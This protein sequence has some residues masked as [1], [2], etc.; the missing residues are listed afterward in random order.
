M[1]NLQSHPKKQHSS[2]KPFMIRTDSL[3]SNRLSD[4]AY[5]LEPPY[6]SKLESE[7]WELFFSSSK[8]SSQ[9][10]AQKLGTVLTCDRNGIVGFVGRIQTTQVINGIKI[11]IVNFGPWVVDER[12]RGHGL[13]LV[14]ESIRGETNSILTSITS[15]ATAVKMVKKCFSPQIISENYHLL[16]EKTFK[17]GKKITHH[18]KNPEK[19]S[20]PEHQRIA[21]DHC[22]YGGQSLEIEINDK[23]LGLTVRHTRIQNSRKPFFRKPMNC[24]EISYATNLGLLHEHQHEISKFLKK[25]FCSEAVI[26]DGMLSP[27]QYGSSMKKIPMISPRLILDK[28]FDDNTTSPQVTPAW[29]YSLYSEVFILGLI[30]G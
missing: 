21:I 28:R 24:L 14:R 3:T 15:S 17:F 29:F 2:G 27:I 19:F 13:K 5:L 1:P 20:N 18:T 23:V 16:D 30:D 11:S 4:I 22:N 12:Y 25:T 7:K 10:P 9:K 26:I 8:F 6:L